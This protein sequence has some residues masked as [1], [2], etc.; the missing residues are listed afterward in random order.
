MAPRARGGGATRPPL[1]PTLHHPHPHPHPLPT[2]PPSSTPNPLHPAT[3]DLRVGRVP[4][5][6]ALWA[7]E[8]RRPLGL[9]GA[10][11]FG[12]QRGAA[13]WA[14][15]GRRPLGL[16][17]APPFGPQRGAAL[18]ASEGRLAHVGA[19]HRAPRALLLS[20]EGL[21]TRDPIIETIPFDVRGA[22]RAPLSRLRE[23]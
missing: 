10:L 11:P 14:S 12:P 2:L 16:R 22:P 6:A 8:G 19:P 20:P 13:L 15:E 23:R 5:A 7:S 4:A 1:L 21:Y 9:R 17:G 18:W 3:D